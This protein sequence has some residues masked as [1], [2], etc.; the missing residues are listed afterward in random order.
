MT[1]PTQ[2]LVVL[3]PG[4]KLDSLSAVPGDFAEWILAEMQADCRSAR[5]IRPHLEDPLPP[6]SSVSVAIVT[7]SSAMLDDPCDW[8]EPCAT[9]LRELV[10][11][12]TPLLGICFGHQLL[13]H[14]LGGKVSENPNGIEVGTVETVLT[15]AAAGDTLFSD[16]PPRLSVQAS[17]RQA[18]TRLPPGAVRLAA[19]A[20]DPNH[21]FRYGENVWGIQF[22]PEFDRDIT[23]AYIEHYR[24]DLEKAGRPVSRMATDTYETTLPRRLLRGFGKVCSESGGQSGQ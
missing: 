20:Q 4:Q 16:L 15:A 10:A 2:G 13:A 1:K 18:V 19:S 9:W 23:R 7:G 14:A 11:Q 3:Q 5:V 6:P 12:G 21:A 17:H 8:I 24:P 22:H